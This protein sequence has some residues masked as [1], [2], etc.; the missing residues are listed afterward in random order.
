MSI[1]TSD[2]VEA[3]IRAEWPEMPMTRFV[4]RDGGIEYIVGPKGND[5]DIFIEPDGVF[6]IW[7]DPETEERECRTPRE[8]VDA[9]RVAL[10]VSA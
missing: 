5:I 9:L 7:D 8:L 6:V 1:W 2:W 10:G 4:G 3:A